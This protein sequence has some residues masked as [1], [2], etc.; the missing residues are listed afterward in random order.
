M[1]HAPE[2]V[3]HNKQLQPPFHYSLILTIITA[4]CCL[5]PGSVAPEGSPQAVSPTNGTPAWASRDAATPSLSSGSGCRSGRRDGSGGVS[6]S[7]S[8]NVNV[9]V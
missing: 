5:A 1:N 2:T 7:I 3:H 8:I 4:S 6:I 9:C